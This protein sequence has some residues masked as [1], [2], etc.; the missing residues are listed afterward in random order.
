MKLKNINIKELK[1]N[2]KILEKVQDK[3]SILPILEYIKFEIDKKD[4][5]YVW[6]TTTDLKSVLSIRMLIQSENM[7]EFAFNL[8]KLTDFLKTNKDN[9][10]DIEV[11]ENVIDVTFTSSKNTLEFETSMGADSFP[12]TIDNTLVLENSFN[13]KKSDF[14]VAIKK[15]INTSQDDIASPYSGVNFT[16][17]DNNLSIKSTDGHFLSI[18][19][20][21]FDYCKDD[22]NFTIDSDKIMLLNEIGCLL[23]DNIEVSWILNKETN[24]LFIIQDNLYF[25]ISLK[26][27]YSQY[28]DLYKVVRKDPEITVEL[29]KKE[30]LE[31]FKV[32]KPVS[33]QVDNRV[34]IKINDNSLNIFTS[35]IK[36]GIKNRNYTID[37]LISQNCD[38]IFILNTQLVESILKCIDNDIIKIDFYSNQIQIIDNKDNINTITISMMVKDWE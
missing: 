20:L 33:K 21:Y 2:L 23:N 5:N 11:S 37:T 19:E 12:T 25:S 9:C 26:Y 13:V 35:N 24:K 15:A 14:L 6:L 18:H 32:L 7:S 28:P 30:L 4:N 38:I 34:K 31:A 27:N 1:E 29:L 36:D 22:F 10:M 8:S 3:K 17:H 16:N